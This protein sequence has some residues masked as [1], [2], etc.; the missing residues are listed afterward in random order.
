VTWFIFCVTIMLSYYPLTFL[1]IF[2]HKYSYIL[3]PLFILVLYYPNTYLFIN[4]P[5]YTPPTYL[6][7]NW[8]YDA[9]VGAIPFF[10]LLLMQ[11]YWNL[12]SHIIF[13]ETTVWPPISCWLYWKLL[14]C[15]TTTT[16]TLMLG[17]DVNSCTNQYSSVTP[18]E[19][20]NPWGYH[21]L[22]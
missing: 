10:L 22:M 15:M 13:T 1:H 8:A 17:C 16:P 18:S 3:L 14:L 11:N 4:V 19:L 20:I 9:N 21:N 5:K 7:L 6:S 12:N 2:H